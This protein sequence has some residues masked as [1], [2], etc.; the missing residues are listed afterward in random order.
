MFAFGGRS[1]SGDL[2]NTMQVIDLLTMEAHTKPVNAEPIE[3]AACTQVSWCLDNETTSKDL[4]IL[5]GGRT[6]EATS[7]LCWSYDPQED[8]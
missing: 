7:R 3:L 8:R 5:C 4:I 2:L 1:I 6:R